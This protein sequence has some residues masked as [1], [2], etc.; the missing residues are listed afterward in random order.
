MPVFHRVK[1]K[2]EAAYVYRFFSKRIVV[3]I[4]LLSIVICFA[5][6][7]VYK[8]NNY[9]L[10]FILFLIPVLASL[11]ALKAGV[12]NASNRFQAAVS[13]TLSGAAAAILFLLITPIHI[14]SFA[15]SFLA[16]EAGKLA[17]LSFFK[18][19]SSGGRSQRT[20]SSEKIIR[21][22]YKNTKIQ[23]LASFI[24][25]LIYPVDIWFAQ[26]VKEVGAVT[27]VEYANKLWNIV[28]LLFTGHIAVTYAAMSKTASASEES[29]KK[30]NVHSIAVRYLVLGT[31]TGIL[32]ISTSDYLV[33]LLFG[34]GKITAQQQTVLSGLLESYLF[35]SGFYIGGLVYVRAL[36][37]AGKINI[38]LIIATYSLCCNIVL[39]AILIKIAG[40]IG[41]GFSTS[42][43]Y[44]S[45]F[46][47][48][49][50]WHKNMMIK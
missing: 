33:S 7:L 45:N 39:D 16:F 22:G 34:F 14:Y 41:I 28:P 32:I 8:N 43:V 4:S 12:L 18:D 6:S 17:W 9:Y 1:N 47:L 23:L 2:D 38:L 10:I 31:I 25:A 40:L 13:G 20:D 11:S 27:F 26:T 30:I 48:F 50:Y 3:Y 21:W 19:I 29:F 5:S 42:I 37:A 46:L 24:M 49:T 44:L 35:G 15:S 36:S